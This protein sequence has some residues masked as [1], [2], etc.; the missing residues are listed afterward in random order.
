MENVEHLRE[1][2]RIRTAWPRSASSGDEAARTE[3][4]TALTGF[5]EFLET[6]Y[7]SFHRIARRWVLS[8]YA[9]VYRWPGD[10]GPGAKPVLFLAHYDV[11]PVEEEKW[12]VPP[13][14]GELRDGYVYGRG[15][16]DMKNILTGMMDAAEELCRNGFKP[17]R[18]L[19][20]A[21]GGD[22]ER[23]G[24]HGAMETVKWF[25][26]QGLEFEWLLDEGG[27]VAEDQIRGVEKPLALVGIEEKGYASLELSVAQAPGHASK[28]PRVQAAAVL[29]QALCRIVK[30][31]FPSRL[32]PTVEQFLT[33]LAP[34]AP[35][36]WAWAVRHPRLFFPVLAA[37]QDRLGPD[38]AAMFHTTTAITQLEGS[39]ADNVLPSAAKVVINLR[40]LQPWTVERAIAA[41][42]KTINDERVEVKVY[43]LGTNPV[44]AAAGQV[45]RRGPGWAALE[46]AVGQVFPGVPILPY[47]MTATTDSRHY[48]ALCAGIFRF[49]PV[50]LDKREL[51][52]IHGHDERVSTENLENCLRFYT[53]L[54]KN[55]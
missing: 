32:I 51:A 48:Q 12:S 44:P 53:C 36:S 45:R 15:A 55:L 26:G 35:K 40:L 33:G 6:A 22:E 27:I 5:Q 42:K 34:F 19:W 46:Q 20:F 18:D 10:G 4:E 21:F 17:R 37:L 7:P 52:L 29:A 11:V 49:C 24:S 41:V 38:I 13:F 43:G 23:N 50:R 14:G 39:A 28:P 2:L 9:V 3:A 47:L 8:P 25:A 54:F 16:L 1:A 31:P 30:K